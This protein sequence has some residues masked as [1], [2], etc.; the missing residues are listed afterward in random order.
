MVRGSHAATSFYHKCSTALV[1]QL[2]R[3]LPT[4]MMYTANA[5][6]DDDVTFVAV[7]DSYWTHASTVDTMN[8]HCRKQFVRLHE[9]PL[10]GRLFE[11]F[12]MYFNGA[13]L[14]QSGSKGKQPRLAE[15]KPPPERGDF[16]MGEVLKSRYFFN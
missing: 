2:G 14:K 10:L 11:F 13:E 15:I 1:Q 12:N 16:Q 5:C 8:V 3:V 7:H 9:Q 6:G 4:H